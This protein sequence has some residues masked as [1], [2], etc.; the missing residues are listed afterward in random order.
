MTCSKSHSKRVVRLGS[1]GVPSLVC[2]EVPGKIIALRTL[3]S[4]KVQFPLK[5]S[6]FQLCLQAP[7][8]FADGACGD[9]HSERTP[10]PLRNP[11][12]ASLRG[13]D[14]LPVNHWR[15]SGS[16]NWYQE[17]TSQAWTNR[18]GCSARSCLHRLRSRSRRVCACAELSTR[19]TQAGS[20]QE[21][22]WPS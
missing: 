18:R 1:W 3:S 9:L 10:T 5:M 15:R 6:F 4:Q 2:D 11:L 8:P 13:L 19:P 16:S 7:I 21:G 20:S 12:G 14:I 17:P 22:A